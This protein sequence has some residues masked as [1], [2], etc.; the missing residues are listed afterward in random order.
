MLLLFII[1]CSPYPSYFAC[2][3]VFL[4]KGKFLP[5]P[6]FPLR[7]RNEDSELSYEMSMINKQSIKNIIIIIY[8]YYQS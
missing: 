3:F 7:L 8:L 5:P 6:A 1:L 4:I 2:T